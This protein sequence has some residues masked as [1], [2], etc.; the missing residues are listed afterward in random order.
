MLPSTKAEPDSPAAMPRAS[1]RARRQAGL[2][3]A[4]ILPSVSPCLT[5]YSPRRPP[6]GAAQPRPA[7]AAPA[8]PQEPAPA[9][10][11]PVRARRRAR[12]PL[13]QR[14]SGAERSAGGSSSTVYSRSTRP[15]GVFSSISSSRKGSLIGP[16]ER[17]ANDCCL[18]ATVDRETQPDQRGVVFE[19]GRP[20]CLL[21]GKPDVEVAGFFGSDRGDLDL[22]PQRLPQS[23]LHRQSAQAR[24]SGFG[25][26]QCDS[27]C[28]G[29]RVSH[30]REPKF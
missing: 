9:R 26:G 8:P 29:E 7:R 23:R 20:I 13:A 3:C 17:H 4:A 1:G 15:D 24:C 22:R 10:P 21:R 18:A 19:I 28:N 5:T 6:L 14:T 30:W 25:R 11:P 2:V 12:V 27:E 16:D